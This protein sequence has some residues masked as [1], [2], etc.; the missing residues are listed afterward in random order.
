MHVDNNFLRRI[1]IYIFDK[2]I[3]TT[4]TDLILKAGN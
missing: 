4:K 3:I 2:I 1:L